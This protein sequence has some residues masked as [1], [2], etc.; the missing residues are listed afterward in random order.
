MSKEFTE[1]KESDS[2]KQFS[3]DDMLAIIELVRIKISCSLRYGGI[4]EHKL[5]SDKEYLQD[6]I[7]R[8]AYFKKMVD[9]VTESKSKVAHE[10]K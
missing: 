1:W 10:A 2:L 5:K 4:G 6:F 8:E 7:E 9:K 3:A